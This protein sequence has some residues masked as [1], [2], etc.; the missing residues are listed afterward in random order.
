M[1]TADSLQ[2]GYKAPS[3]EAPALW[4]ARAIY[5]RDFGR[6]LYRTE[7]L[8]DRQDLKADTDE[9]REALKR[10]LNGTAKRKGALH[11]FLKLADAAKF[12]GDVD[13]DEKAASLDVDGV[14]FTFWTAG[15]SGYLYITAR[16]AAKPGGTP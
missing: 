13:I 9:A 7:L 10:K 15:Q 8:W 14:T 4:G 6:N 3:I 11:R 2:W 5:G 1:A 12:P 16:L